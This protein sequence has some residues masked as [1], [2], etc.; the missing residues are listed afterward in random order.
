MGICDFHVIL[1][2][3]LVRGGKFSLCSNLVDWSGDCEKA[4]TNYEIV[5]GCMKVTLLQRASKAMA[6]GSYKNI[7][8]NAE[9][10]AV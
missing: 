3:S 2:E 8:V 1:L 9:N 7:P 5:V 10:V 4:Y 6:L